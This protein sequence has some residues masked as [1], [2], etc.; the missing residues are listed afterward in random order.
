MGKGIYCELSKILKSDY[1]KKWYTHNQ[2]SVLETHKLCRDF[3][4]QTDHLIL[5]KRQDLMIVNNNKENQLN[6]GLYRPGWVKIKVRE[7]RQT[8]RPCKRTKKTQTKNTKKLRKMR[9]TVIPVVTSVLGTIPRGLVT[10][11]KDLDRGQV[12][13]IQI[14]S[15]LDRPEYWEESRR[16][17]KTLCHSNSSEKPSANTGVKNFQKS[18]VIIIRKT[19]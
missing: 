19:F 5:A 7:K 16:L 2:E 10:R 13:T 8:P 14:T 11:L 18:K 3:E 1:I 9:V 4:I 12:E 17:E 15:L 6:S